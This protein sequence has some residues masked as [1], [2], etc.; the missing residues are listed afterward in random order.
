[1]SKYIIHTMPKRMWYV[2]GY[3][4]PS[5]VK[6]GIS[7]EDIQIY[8]DI[9]HLGCLNACMDCFSDMP[10]QGSTWHLQDDVIISHDFK[11]VTEIPYDE[12]MIACGFSSA[13]YDKDAPAG[14]VNSENMWF[15]F[16]CILIPNKWAREC[17]DWV[18]QYII[19]NPVYREYWEKGLNDDWCFRQY[20]KTFYHD[21]SIINITPNIVD[22]IDWLIGG[23]VASDYQRKS[24]FRSQYW[25]DNYLVEE[26]ERK[27]KKCHSGQQ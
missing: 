10:E 27:L 12:N 1:M 25:N 18:R 22:H 9:K 15:S 7:K 13:L 21:C 19:G 8:N 5:M 2:C 20:I 17:A 23:S 11:K 24:E 26:L 3:L 16:Q 4:I 6:Q 14:I